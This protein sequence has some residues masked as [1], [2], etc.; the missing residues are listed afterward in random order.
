MGIKLS[1]LPTIIEG[2]IDTVLTSRFNKLVGTKVKDLI[3][4][5][6]R[7]GRGVDKDGDSALPLKALKKQT[8]LRRSR[9]KKHGKLTGT[10]ATPAKS[11]VNRS[12]SLLNTLEVKANKTSFTIKPSFENQNKAEFLDD[13]GFKFLNASKAEINFVEKE[14][15][16]EIEKQIIRNINILGK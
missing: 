8:K 9:L 2:A 5:R 7:L 4:K 16:K 13:K 1:D 12:G 11:A 15:T 6:T 3:V 10:G 14:L